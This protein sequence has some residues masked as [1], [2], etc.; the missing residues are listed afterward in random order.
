MR[1]AFMDLNMLSFTPTPQLLNLMFT[2][3]TVIMRY[4]HYVSFSNIAQFH[5]YK[6]YIVFCNK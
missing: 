5:I 6:V 4:L 1:I 2:H 3:A